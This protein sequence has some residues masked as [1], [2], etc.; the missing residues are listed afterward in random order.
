MLCVF[1]ASMAAAF[2]Q[3]FTFGNAAFYNLKIGETVN[4]MGRSVTLESSTRQFCDFSVDGKKARLMVSRLSLPVLV[5]GLRL[6]L[7]HNAHVKGLTDDNSV[8]GLLTKD[9][10]LCLSDA[11][12]PLLAPDSYTFPISR[13]DGY[14]WPMGEESHMF[15]YLGP[16]WN[17]KTRFRSHEG[18]DFNMHDGRGIKKH[19]IV[20]VEDGAVVWS[21]R[22]LGGDQNEG[23]ILIKS[24]LNPD[25]YYVY[26]HMYSKYMYV[27]DGDPVKKGDI[28]GYVWGDGMWGHLHFSIVR[29]DVPPQYRGRYENSLNIFPQMHELWSGISG[30]G[31]PVFTEGDFDFGRIKGESGNVRYNIAYTPV[32]GYGWLIDDWCAAGNLEA[33]PYE[34]AEG[35]VLLKKVVHEDSRAEAVNPEDYFD[36]EVNVENG[37]Y[38]VKVLVGDY[39]QRSFQRV[40]IEGVDFGTWDLGRGVVKWTPRQEVEVEDGKLT[41]RIH[42]QPEQRAGICRLIFARRDKR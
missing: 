7:A 31:L 9:A 23:C 35:F 20:A 14:R 1:G 22:E 8:H 10:L 24:A 17:D 30:E 28:L 11:S 3:D 27:S 18:I 29:R 42:L 39:Y 5:D 2:G 34:Q 6:Y 32:T 13:R 16:R 19:P 33:I 40:D 21:L 38:D 37:A 12:V 36:F 41:V 4:Y 25:I 26:K 15:G